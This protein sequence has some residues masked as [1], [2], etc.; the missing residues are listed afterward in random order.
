LEQV[1]LKRAK[2]REELDSKRG[3]AAKKEKTMTAAAVQK[4]MVDKMLDQINWV[5]RRI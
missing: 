2:E 4:T 1:R 3:L 5:H